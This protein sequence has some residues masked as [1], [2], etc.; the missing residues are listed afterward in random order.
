[1]YQN[2]NITDVARSFARLNAVPLV[3]AEDAARPQAFVG[4]GGEDREEEAGLWCS[5]V[6]SYP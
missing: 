5:L 4:A 2:S 6:I 3:M 1:L